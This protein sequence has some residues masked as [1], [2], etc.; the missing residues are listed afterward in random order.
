M[1]RLLA[2]ITLLLLSIAYT[3]AFVTAPAFS[4]TSPVTALNVKVEVVV[5]DGEPID[6]ALSRFQRE[7]VKSG[8]L[9]ELRHRRFFENKQQKLKR[10]RREAGLRRRYERL[11]RRKMSQRNA[12]IN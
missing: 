12:G 3:G 11:Q 4:R 10:K 1:A 5:G 6:S 2:V 8:H 9:M 7:V